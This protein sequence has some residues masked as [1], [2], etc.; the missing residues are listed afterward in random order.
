MFDDGLATGTVLGGCGHRKQARGE[1]R[2]HRDD[3]QLVCCVAKVQCCDVSRPV[4]G[5]HVGAS[6]QAGLVPV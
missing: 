5:T 3:L 1:E 4:V 2:A 6:G